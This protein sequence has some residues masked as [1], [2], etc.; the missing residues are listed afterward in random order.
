MLNV[1]YDLCTTLSSQ[2][3]DYFTKRIPFYHT[4]FTLFVLSRASDNTTSQ[5]IGG[6][7]ACAVPLWVGYYKAVT[8]EK[9]LC[10]GNIIWFGT[11]NRL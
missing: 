10:P 8:I 1:V 7:D 4:F 5:N 3:N 9:T 11:N 6:T 2:Q